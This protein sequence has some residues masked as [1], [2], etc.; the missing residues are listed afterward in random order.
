MFISQMLSLISLKAFDCLVKKGGSLTGT[1]IS[2][3]RFINEANTL[4]G[5]LLSCNNSKTI[6]HL[7]AN[8]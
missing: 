7:A 5:I 8:G 2:K 4:D 6:F 1:M 3:I